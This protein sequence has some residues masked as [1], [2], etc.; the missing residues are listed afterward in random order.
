MAYVH[1]VLLLHQI[2]KV[3]KSNGIEVVIRREPFIHFLFFFFFWSTNSPL[4]SSTVMTVYSTFVGPPGMSEVTSTAKGIEDD[5]CSVTS[6]TTNAADELQNSLVDTD[7][8]DQYSPPSSP[9][10]NCGEPRSTMNDDQ[11]QDS[12]HSPSA[13]PSSGS[14]YGY[15]VNVALHCDEV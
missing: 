6:V 13:V 15:I 1:C 11:V 8:H 3:N 10:D 12:H 9:H 4:P 14:E 7:G 2:L 5:M